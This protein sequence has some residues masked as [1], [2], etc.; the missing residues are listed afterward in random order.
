MLND[1]STWQKWDPDLKYAEI[2]TRLSPDT[3]EGAQGQVHMNDGKTFDLTIHDISLERGEFAYLTKLTGA[4]LDWYWK[5]T[6][7]DG[8]Q[9]EQG[10][11]VIGDGASGVVLTE[12]I[13]ARGWLSGLYK[14]AIEK[15]CAEACEQ[16]LRNMGDIC[17]AE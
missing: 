9:G 7:V 15:R 12:G 6:A 16:A 1:V 3:L 17:D 8:R 4:D 10:Q 13:E 11:S 2:T 14:Y 5:W